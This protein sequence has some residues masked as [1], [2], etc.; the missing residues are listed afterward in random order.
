[1]LFIRGSGCTDAGRLRAGGELFDQGSSA[2]P[3]PTEQVLAAN[4]AE[5][6]GCE[7]THVTGPELITK[8]VLFTPL[9][10]DKQPAEGL[11]G[12]AQRSFKPPCFSLNAF[13]V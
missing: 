11:Q 7:N 8:W 3:Q 2:A 9:K 4:P 5:V 13:S 1:M 6:A 10:S 12:V